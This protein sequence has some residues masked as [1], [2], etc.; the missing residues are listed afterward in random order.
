MDPVTKRQKVT[1]SRVSLVTITCC[2]QKGDGQSTEHVKEQTTNLKMKCVI[3]I[4]SKQI[5]WTL[6]PP[7]LFKH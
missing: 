5:S 2:K 4:V 7:P 1:H 6:P 3:S